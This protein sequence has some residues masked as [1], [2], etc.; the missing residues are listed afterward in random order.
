MVRNEKPIAQVFGVPF[1]HRAAAN[2][3]Q[4]QYT[5]GSGSSTRTVSFKEPIRGVILYEQK[6]RLIPKR[7]QIRKWFEGDVDFEPMFCALY[8]PFMLSSSHG[9]SVHWEVQL[10]HPQFVDHELV[11][12]GGLFFY[13]D[14]LDG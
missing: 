7:S 4:G 14:F 13:E 5:R 1:S 10:I 12:P 3:E 6:V 9:L 8:P 11:G 2:M